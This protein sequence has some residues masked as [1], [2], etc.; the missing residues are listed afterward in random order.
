MNGLTRFLRRGEAKR[1]SP[2]LTEDLSCTPTDPLV[3]R[4]ERLPIVQRPIS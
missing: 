1:N 2:P 4:L 3:E